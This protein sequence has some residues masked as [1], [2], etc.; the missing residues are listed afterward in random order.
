MEVQKILFSDSTES[1]FVLTFKKEKLLHLVSSF[2]LGFL[3]QVPYLKTSSTASI[4][5]QAVGHSLIHVHLG[6]K[7]ML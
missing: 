2:Q 5:E 3:I 7:L 6:I 4:A 1:K